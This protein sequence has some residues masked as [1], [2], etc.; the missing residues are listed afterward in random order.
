[1]GHKPRARRRGKTAAEVVERW[2]AQTGGREAHVYTREFKG[3][4]VLMFVA[5]EPVDAETGLG[6]G[7]QAV[8]SSEI[9]NSP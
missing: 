4:H 5:G 1:M 7:V 2:M 9:T 6:L 8:I 3:I